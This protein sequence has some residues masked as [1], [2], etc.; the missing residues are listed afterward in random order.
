MQRYFSIMVLVLAALICGGTVIAQVS[1]GGSPLGLSKTL[2]AVVATMTMPSVDV[3]ALL[4]EDKI[5][6]AE[7]LPYRFGNPFE[8]NYNLDN[9]GTWTDLNDGGRVWRL[10]IQS[11]GAYSI[12]LIYDRYYLPEGARLFL[13]NEDMTMII[14]AFT[15]RNN[16]D[17]GQFA[18]GPVKGD[19]TILEYYEPADVRSE[20]QINIS[21]VIHA[22]KNI[23]SYDASKGFLDYGESG[24]CNNNVNC[25]VGDDWQDD[26]RAVAMILT[27]GGSRICSGSLINNVR[28][29][30]T[31]YFLTANHCLGGETTWIFMFNYES[32]S[33]TNA[34]GPTTQTVSGCVKRANYATSDFALL[35]LSEQPPASYNVYYA[36]WSN[37]DTPS[38]GSTCIH[39]PSGD[40]KKISFD[41]DPA[42]SADYLGTSGTTHWRITAWD[43]GTTEPGSSGSPL[44][45]QNHRIVGQLHGGY[46]SCTS[47]TSD[48]FGKF[49]MSW[50]GGGASASRLKTWLDPDNTGTALLDGFDPNAGVSITHTSLPNTI[51]TLIPYEVICT[52]KSN[53]TL[54]SDS[55]LLFY[56]AP[57]TWNTVLLE[58][59]ANADEF[60]GYIPAQSAGTTVNYYL[61]AKD[62]NGTADTTSTFTF[63]VLYVPAIAVAPA[64]FDNTLGQGDSTVNNLI[65]SNTSH[66]ELTYSLAIMPQL[67]SGQTVN[68]NSLLTRLQA[69]GRLAPASRTYPEGFDDYDQT[70]G[71]EDTR[72]GY[73]VDKNAGGPDQ[74]GY[75]WV[76]SDDPDGPVFEWAD[77]SAT[78]TDVIGGLTDDSYTGPIAIGFDFPYYGTNYNQ[79][80]I[81]SNGIIGFDTTMMKSRSKT[82]LPTATTPNNILAWL[83]DDL[84][85]ADTV[86][87]NAHVYV[88]SDADRCVIEFLDYPEYRGDLGDV[89]TAEVI[90]DNDGAITY[91]YQTIASGFD[92]LSCA[93][94]M[95]NAAGTDGIEIAYLAAYLHDNLAIRIFHP[96]PWLTLSKSS[97]S[98]AFGLSDTVICQITATGLDT[99]S[100]VS[101]IIISSNDP[102]AGDNPW[103]VPAYLTVK[104][105]YTCGDANSDSKV[106]IAD[107]VYLISYIFRSGPAP[108]P[109]PAGDANCD[110]K[111]NVADAVYIIAYV[112]RGGPEP[113]CP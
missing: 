86:N 103:T 63:Q 81:G 16:K 99:G 74:F 14:G 12:N 91:Q 64:S 4:A 57:T 28:Q 38:L 29:D 31:P 7:G 98:V 89:V 27:S 76:D 8:V 94:G 111:V 13:Y 17:H 75:F 78:G 113:C 47:I 87:V 67:K 56:A 80:Y 36:G 39:H 41:Y 46:A 102:D 53:G 6:E 32:P 48:W 54:E 96:Y 107:A 1:E 77:I 50:N 24:S 62:Y 61:F 100:Y 45:D 60:H 72:Q 83:W 70:K 40:I 42:T 59:T 52:I 71:I 34:N 30:E 106:N 55:L 65:I 104:S 23:F 101:D 68:T 35:E 43:D 108:L 22:Y 109:E 88:Y 105:P 95:E 44:F 66:G 90:L 58:S 26:N 110:G 9:S 10:R 69:A 84:N 92:I 33:C 49:A 51:D 82:H 21:R 20:G 11:P 93:V 19:V 79:L 37:V 112:F 15:A 2:P 5:E 85:P 25:P 73:A 3:Q 97:G 18:T